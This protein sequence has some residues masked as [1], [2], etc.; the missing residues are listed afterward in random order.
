LVGYRK[1]AGIPDRELPL[2]QVDLNSIDIQIRRGDEYGND[3]CQAIAEMAT[4]LY[5]R[6]SA[7]PA[8]LLRSW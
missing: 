4:R 2:F 5:G 6:Q 8:W 1:S 3:P 7:L